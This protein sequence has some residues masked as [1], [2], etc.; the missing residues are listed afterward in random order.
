MAI[1]SCTIGREKQNVCASVKNYEVAFSIKEP[2]E[3][4]RMSYLS[5]IEDQLLDIIS[6]KLCLKMGN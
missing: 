4:S 5:K 1:L 3:Y 6:K 2:S